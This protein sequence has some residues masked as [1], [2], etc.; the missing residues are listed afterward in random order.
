VKARA[1]RGR[2]EVEKKTSD[3]GSHLFLRRPPHLL[4]PPLL[5]PFR[6]AH[7][8]P[9]PD[10]NPAIGGAEAAP[11]P[12]PAPATEPTDATAVPEEEEE[13]G[14]CVFMKGGGCKDQFEVRAP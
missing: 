8:H 3:S 14:F 9:M 6:S 10:L 12:P 2:V 4:A 13:C 11:A 5:P 7:P 1:R